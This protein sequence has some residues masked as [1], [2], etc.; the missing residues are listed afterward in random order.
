MDYRKLG[1]AA[2]ATMGLAAGTVEAQMPRHYTGPQVQHHQSHP[3]QFQG[4]SFQPVH[5]S[6]QHQNHA[7]GS[8]HHFQPTPQFFQQ[9]T[10]PQFFQQPVMQPQA[11]NLPLPV[12]TLEFGF[13][14]TV[15]ER[16]SGPE[17]LGGLENMFKIEFAA[18]GYVTPNHMQ[19]TSYDVNR[20]GIFNIWGVGYTKALDLGVAQLNVGDRISFVKVGSPPGNNTLAVEPI[21]PNS[22]TELVP[23]PAPNPSSH[24][25]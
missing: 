6:Y 18:P 8:S 9:L 14:L 19:T 7:R 23:T 3:H 13:Y 24:Q 21:L 4:H 22:G 25:H 5:H 10:Q 20:A 11:E 16:K 12:N 15:I 17:V 1:L 2:L